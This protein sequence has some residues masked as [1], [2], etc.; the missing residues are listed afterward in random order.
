MRI[1][2]HP[3]SI[4]SI[5]LQRRNFGPKNGGTNCPTVLQST[6]QHHFDGTFCNKVVK[7]WGTVPHFKKWGTRPPVPPESYAYVWLKSLHWGTRN[8]GSRGFS[9]H[10][11]YEGNNEI[12]LLWIRRSIPSKTLPGHP[13]VTGGSR[14]P[15]RSL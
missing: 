9:L 11:E 7:K 4:I 14:Q 15:S 1:C 3:S 5:W 8:W 12:R 6:K 10:T 13:T 2:H